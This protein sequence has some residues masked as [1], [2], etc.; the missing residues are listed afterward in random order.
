M[1]KSG[2]PMPVVMPPSTRISWPVMKALA[3]G[4]R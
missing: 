1:E 4:A 3:S 2:P